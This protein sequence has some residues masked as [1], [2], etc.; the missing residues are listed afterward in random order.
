[1]AFPLN[2]DSCMDFFRI[3]CLLPSTLVVINKTITRRKLYYF[4]MGIARNR[5]YANILIFRQC[6][7]RE[8]FY[9]KDVWFLLFNCLMKIVAVLGYDLR[10]SNIQLFCKIMKYMNNIFRIQIYKWILFHFS[11]SRCRGA[12]FGC[13]G[14]IQAILENLRTQQSYTVLTPYRMNCTG[15]G[16]MVSHLTVG[17]IDLNCLNVDFSF[18]EGKLRRFSILLG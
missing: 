5:S 16:A 17:I 15:T 9:Q 12:E 7:E 8:F 2:S 3:Q 18:Q 1:M 4:K 10:F 11:S 13:N 6:L 14:G